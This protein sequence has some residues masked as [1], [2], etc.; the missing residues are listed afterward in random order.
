MSSIDTRIL[1]MQFDNQQFESGVKTSMKT[2][3]NL[4]SSLQLKNATV[5]V[6]TLN[7][8]S[9]SISS[10]MSSVSSNAAV[11][12]IA[13]GV[14][15]LTQ[16]FTA[17]GVAGVAAI[18]NIT[19]RL[20]NMAIGMAKS[21]T[22]DPIFTGF[23]EY[24]IKMKSIKTIL[25]NTE[26]AGTTLDDV[27]KSL[28]DLNEYADK[29]IYNFAQMTDNI[30]K[31]TAAGVD[32]DTS[33]QSI[34]GI[35]NIAAASGVDATRA[36]G[37]MYQL[38]QA[39]AAGKVQL[40]DWKSV[41]NA[42]MG[43]KL[44]KDA[45]IRT[46]EVMGTGANAA[47]KKYGSFN[48]SLTR[49][50]WLTTDVL[51]ETLQ[52]F[53]GAYTE[54]DLVAKGYTKQQAKDIVKMAESATEAA[55]QVR[56]VTQLFDTAA[57]NVQSGWAQSWEYIIGDSEQA[58]ELLTAISQGFEKI[59]G[60][61]TE[62]RNN[63]LQFWNENGGRA[64]VIEGLG[65]VMTSL[66]KVL[67]AVSKA[68][69][70][71]FPRTTGKKLVEISKNFKDLTEKLKV[72]NKTA[73]DIQKA[74][75]GVFSVVKAG[76]DIFVSIA[77]AAGKVALKFSEFLPTIFAISGKLGE[78]MTYVVES[79]KKLNLFEKASEAINEKLAPLK[80]GLS[81]AGKEFKELFDTFANSG[82]EALEPIIDGVAKA[83][84]ILGDVFLIVLDAIAKVFGSIDL[85]N[86]IK[87]INSL[88]TTGLLVKLGNIIDKFGGTADTAAKF[89]DRIKK[90]LDALKETL[91]TYQS[92]LKAGILMKIATAIGILAGALL[93]LSFIDPERLEGA[94]LSMGLLFAGM[95]GSMALF[96]KMM[97]DN[98]NLK[99]IIKVPTA[100]ILLSTALL[101]L[102]GAMKT[103]GNLEWDEIAKGLVA[104]T[105]LMTILMVTTKQLSGQ[106]GV[107]V[108]S[109]LAM[110]LFAQALKMLVEP[111][112]EL[113]KTNPEQLGIGVMAIG[114]L[115]A[116]IAGFMEIT[117]KLDGLGVKQSM[118]IVL[119][120]GAMV[121][122]AK[123]INEFSKMNV[124][125][126]TMG[127]QTLGATL[128]MI[129]GFMKITEKVGGLISLGA[130]LAI[131]AG[132]MYIFAGAMKEMSGMSWEE[133]QKGFTGIA[134]ALASVA[135]ALQLMPKENLLKSAASLVVIS[136]ALKVLGDIIKSLGEMSFMQV[137]TS[138]VVL[139]GSLVILAGAM[140]QMVTC[141][142]GAQAMVI[143]AAA[144]A[145]FIPQ[146]ML[147]ANLDL[148][149]IMTGLLTLGGIFVI[150][151][152]GAIALTP[153]LPTLTTL[154]GAIALLGVACLGVGLGLLAFSTAMSMLAV[155]G[156]AG[157]LVLLGMLN[158][159]INLIPVFGQKVAEMFLTFL[160]AITEAVPKIK[161][162][163]VI[164]ATALLDGLVQLIPKVIEAA[165]QLGIGILDALLRLLPTFVEV[166]TKVIL[167]LLQGISDSIGKIT[168]TAVNII[169]GFVEALLVRI[170]ELVSA[171]MRLVIAFINGLASAIDEHTPELIA[172]GKRLFKS[173]I[174]AGIEVIKAMFGPMFNWGANLIKK[175][176]D[177][178]KGKYTEV[179]NAAFGLDKK[180]DEALK[181][182]PGKMWNI[183]VNCVKS[184]GNGL[185][186]LVTYVK[187]KAAGIGSAAID[188]VKEVLG[189]N[190]PSREF[191]KVGSGVVEG[192]V[193]GIHDNMR[194]VD[195]S[196]AGIGNSAIK[197]IQ[198]P[199]AALA[200]VLDSD[201][202]M[203]PVITPVVDLSN[204]QAGAKSMNGLLSQSGSLSLSTG[205]GSITSSMAKIQ[206][207][208]NNDDVVSAIKGLRKD[209]SEMS[210]NTYQIN[211]V[212]YDDGS[213][214]TSAV[215]TL[216]RAAK[217]ERRV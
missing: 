91:E 183:G 122:F 33:V 10:T 105:G 168:D 152:Q 28:N 127:I 36:S 203:N 63:M 65:N 159:L 7:S 101:I 34:K 117:K 47:I 136:Y 201:M 59:V 58:P 212:T 75:K 3:E 174:N 70:E 77:K 157:G 124:D 98:K 74:F 173:L 1:Q 108:K 48:E 51:T 194:D 123:A 9:N 205:F 22:V 82:I 161:E 190:S 120:A 19:N 18:T 104:T 68:F 21:L 191:A 197:A 50:G 41:V 57:E 129:A 147:L 204:V 164:I 2:L 206:N 213:N 154:A 87:N 134:G 100:M 109:G 6:K 208:N 45:L 97:G 54:A 198:T 137:L 151:A 175:L 150:L 49:S 125:Q 80:E 53:A 176:I 37:A 72:S 90:T 179:K 211:G 196:S 88:L 153:I 207:G 177:G 184:L 13:A 92:S 130:S 62:A 192:F 35:A 119:M 187:D 155:S 73:K 171:G 186:S 162:S 11:Q 38:S 202:D 182:L 27:K 61:S 96:F 144:L 66:G 84:K 110:M 24:E 163:V 16:K 78:F 102:A 118:G 43:G 107:I 185:W 106:E 76:V 17:L 188:K 56:T 69:R 135:L 44:F 143:M 14:E 126:Y 169:M 172:A 148:N 79:T 156:S 200:K 30:G 60:P 112:K 94:I 138:L 199:M 115:M 128:L 8:V 216:V 86:I 15:S 113:G 189:I 12:N 195:K 5:G 111:V 214:I 139:G 131:I 132:S 40:M 180:I 166:G 71:V 26:H 29:T 210:N 23:S 178:I 141:I 99:G 39:L 114:A 55:T 209:I 165:L 158:S 133:L 142:P 20:T 83:G 42:G 217:I 121:I 95:M 31:F 81:K 4:N 46:S 170:P 116:E 67:G 160:Q 145:I 167:A 93:V 89:I 64:A 140:K 193:K 146:F 52:Q 32:L 85:N 215:E 103:V 181:S 25:T 149:Q